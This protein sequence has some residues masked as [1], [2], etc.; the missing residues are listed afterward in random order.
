VQPSWV[1]IDSEL[2]QRL[3]IAEQLTIDEIAARLRCSPTTIRRRLRAGAISP[4]PRG[5]NPVRIAGR[6]VSTRADITWSPALAWIVGLIATD[7]NLSR[8]R[9]LSIT[10]KD[11][12][13]L[14]DVKRH[15]KLT[16]VIGTV[17]GSKGRCSRL[18]WGDRFF[19]GWLTEVGLTPAKSLTLGPLLIPDAYFADF[20]RGCIDGDGSVFVYTDRYHTR[21]DERYIYQ[22]LYVS[23]V[24]ASRPFIE[25]TQRCVLRLA[26]VKG[27]M[28]VRSS[29]GHNP[30]WKLRYAKAESIRVLRWMYYEPSIPA[31]ARKRI[32]AAP[33]LIPRARPLRRGPGRPVVV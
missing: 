32:V 14:E 3:Y 25:W 16:N 18:Q 17:Q 19:Y 27:R 30:L 22:R 7:G 11:V 13:L 33:F 12:D 9:R 29:K 15:L 2:L 24:S 10:S 8:Q 5:P 21:K 31:L 26:G 20:F 4:R 23:L 1:S 28:T 6:D